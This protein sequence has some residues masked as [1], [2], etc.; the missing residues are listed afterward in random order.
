[1]AAA[2]LCAAQEL[3]AALRQVSNKRGNSS[4]AAE[5][6]ILDEYNLHLYEKKP[7]L[8]STS[9]MCIVLPPLP[10]PPPPPLDCIGEHNDL[11]NNSIIYCRPAL[12]HLLRASG[13]EH[14]TSHL[15]PHTIL[16]RQYN[17]PQPAATSHALIHAIQMLSPPLGQPTRPYTIS[18]REQETRRQ[19]ELSP[20]FP[21]LLHYGML[22][23]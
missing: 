9:D 23:Y 7:P 22:L 16:R 5:S 10:S 1:M 17:Q 18:S 11:R 6:S 19:K 12:L 20:P 4:A 21:P 3:H 15:S 14:N 8:I 13:K 2:L